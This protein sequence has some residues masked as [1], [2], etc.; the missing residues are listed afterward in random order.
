MRKNPFDIN[1][2][3]VWKTIRKD[4]PGLKGKLEKILG[5]LS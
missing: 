2:E 4:I 1:I 3:R 5:K